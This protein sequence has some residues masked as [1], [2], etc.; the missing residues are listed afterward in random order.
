MRIINNTSGPVYITDLALRV[1]SSPVSIDATKTVYSS[2]LIEAVVKGFVSLEILDSEKDDSA[3]RQYLERLDDA[4][5][6]SKG[7]QLAEQLI[8]DIKKRTS[9]CL[10]VRPARLL[11][12]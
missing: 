1:G 10:S 6:L 8:E 5:A 9:N 4:T 12:Q 11:E 3:V 7:K 2:N